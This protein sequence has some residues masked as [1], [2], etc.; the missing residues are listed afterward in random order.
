[1]VAKLSN[2]WL[3]QRAFLILSHVTIP[4]WE[5]SYWIV[6][7]QENQL[8]MDLTGKERV[9]VMKA[10]G[11]DSICKRNKRKWGNK[12]PNPK[13]VTNVTVG[14]ATGSNYMLIERYVVFNNHPRLWVE[15]NVWI[16]VNDR[17]VMELDF[18][19]WDGVPRSRNSVLVGLRSY[20]PSSIELSRERCI[21]GQDNLRLRLLLKEND[22][23]ELC[24]NTCLKII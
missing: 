21:K 3:E 20:Q 9:T 16:A 22:K 2:C 14:R 13:N 8:I 12:V 10:T 11:N 18:L 23:D 1:M 5:C 7:N 17:N 6:W 24:F 15:R 4:I 19:S